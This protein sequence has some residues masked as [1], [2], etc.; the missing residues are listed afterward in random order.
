MNIWKLGT[1]WG[2]GKRSFYEYIK[3][4]E[5]IISHTNNASPKKGDYML[6]TDGFTVLAIAVLLEDAQSVTADPSLEEEFA[7][8]E[9]EYYE[10][11]TYAAAKYRVLAEDERFR[12]ETRQGIVQ[13]KSKTTINQTLTAMG[14]MVIIQQ[15]CFLHLEEQRKKNPDLYFRLR[16][17]NRDQRLEKGYW[18]WG[19]DEYCIISF[20]LGDDNL[21]KIP[22]IHIRIDVTGRA[23]LLLTSRDNDEKASFLKKIA[24]M[25]G[26]MQQRKKKGEYMNQWEKYYND[27]PNYIAVL[28][29]FI[30]REKEIIDAFLLLEKNK[31][32]NN[33]GNLDFID[34][35]TFMAQYEN[36]KYFQENFDFDPFET[37]FKEEEIK[38]IEQIELK[39]LILENIGH[40]ERIELDLNHRII[41]LLGHNGSGKSTILR[42]LALGLIGVDDNP[43][44]DTNHKSIQDLLR[45]ST[46]GIN[47]SLEHP[48]IGRIE[49]VYKLN[50]DYTN[51]IDIKK[52]TGM[53]IIGFTND[54]A[55]EG[56]VFGLNDGSSLYKCLVLGFAQF[57]G[58]S[59]KLDP[60]TAPSIK[61]NTYDILP[62]LYN[63]DNNRYNSLGEWLMQVEA[64]SQTNKKNEKALL[65]F[66]FKVLSLI[67]EADI[68][69]DTVEHQEGLIWLKMDGKRML[70]RLLSQGF[71]NVF[72]WVGHLIRRLYESSNFEENFNS[73]PAIVLIDEIDTYLHPKWQRK[74]LDVLAESFPNAQF[75]VTTHSPLVASH[76]EA[77]GDKAV[78]Y[79]LKE[80]PLNAI[81][82]ADY[83]IP[84]YK[85]E[86]Y[87]ETYGRDITSIFFD[88]MEVEERDK[89]VQKQINDIFDWIDEED[90]ESLAKAEKEIE[91]LNLPEHDPV[92]VKLK[93]ALDFAKDDL[94]D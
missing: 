55:Q 41:C 19:N 49:L 20:W 22:N 27:A 11:V 74:I 35:P 43:E 77:Q 62:L 71:K 40:F 67:I 79:I 12:Y 2:T 3:D 36:V 94:D 73:Y 65:D 92:M 60:L 16:Q 93:M 1:K 29:E 85:V 31:G 72:A 80:A 89:D 54:L 59:I 5:I 61:P 51:T 84:E 45:V 25:I 82:D 75:I 46:L 70:Y 6:I 7:E 58:N 28:D 76:V 15:K 90:P 9:I 86:V 30:T 91:A 48:Y 87:E 50:K 10:G 47:N 38:G 37:P 64:D 33:L 26:G 23:N 34:Q 83:L 63:R 32:G 13:V 39:K 56:N 44:L 53:S 4:K 66:I 14:E 42:A 52:D 21:S 24:G 57:Q 68:K 88:W 81:D 17:R 18:F 8:Y 78:V 69:L